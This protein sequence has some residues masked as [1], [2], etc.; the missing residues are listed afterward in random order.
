MLKTV[1]KCSQ[2]ACVLLPRQLLFG[3]LNVLNVCL[4][5]A[6]LLCL[7]PRQ[8]QCKR[9]VIGVQLLTIILACNLLFNVGFIWRKYAFKLFEAVFDVV[10]AEF[11]FIVPT[12]LYLQIVDVE[13]EHVRE[14]V[15]IERNNI[16]THVRTELQH[17]WCQCQCN[18]LPNMLAACAHTFTNDC[19]SCQLW[20][21]GQAVRVSAESVNETWPHKMLLLLHSPDDYGGPLTIGN[22]NS[23]QKRKFVS[24]ISQIFPN[25]LRSSTSVRSLCVW[26]AFRHD[27]KS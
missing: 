15:W 13:L 5:I 2:T 27:R 12:I 25:N 3:A 22:K 8:I 24:H 20:M 7:A 21:C 23:I 19:G 17:H 4:P 10:D 9:W 16:Y 14:N 11:H 18:V 1:H 26:M 6:V